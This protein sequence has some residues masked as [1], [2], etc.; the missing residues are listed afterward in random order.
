MSPSLLLNHLDVFPDYRSPAGHC[1]GR[2]SGHRSSRRA[3]DQHRSILLL[4]D[5]GCRP[6]HSTRYDRLVSVCTLKSWRHTIC[7]STHH[8][9]HGHSK[10]AHAHLGRR[11]HH[12]PD[13]HSHHCNGLPLVDI[14]TCWNET[15]DS[16]VADGRIL[17]SGV[18]SQKKMTGET[19][20]YIKDYP[21]ND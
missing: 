6:G 7:R 15:V 1:P 20:P 19:E 10:P 11:S 13:G 2:S 8:H 12:V 14:P 9:S 3:A 21:L 4:A 18:L 16:S 17:V 5:C